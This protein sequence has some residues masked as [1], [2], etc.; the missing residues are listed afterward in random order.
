METNLTDH[1]D[2]DPLTDCLMKT[3]LTNHLMKT[4]PTDHLMKT[5]LTD[6]LDGDHPNRPPKEDHL[7]ERKSVAWILTVF[8]GYYSIVLSFI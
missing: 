6:H 4:T 5:T 8:C 2:Q 1:P 3:T 7:D